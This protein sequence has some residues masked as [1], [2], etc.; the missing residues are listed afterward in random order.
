MSTQSH[1]DT[2]TGKCLCGG[3]TFTVQGPPNAVYCCYCKDC[4]L[5]A[6]GPCQI[7]ASYPSSEFTLQDADGLAT[8]FAIPG[9]VSGKPK[10]KYFCRR[11]GCTLF[12]I[13]FAV[14]LKEIVIRPALV[15]N[16]LHIFRP[17]IECF[18]ERRPE[19]FSACE[20]AVQYQTS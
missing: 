2:H 20:N 18:A 8:R 4:S 3:I 10:D 6:G 9:T 1:A 13:P 11:C 12:T 7:T 15:E 14:G 17:S 5:G 16:G 19:Y